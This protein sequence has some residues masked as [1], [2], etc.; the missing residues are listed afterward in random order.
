[1][2][3]RKYAELTEAEIV[4]GWRMARYKFLDPCHGK[5]R[6][7]QKGRRG[8]KGV[9]MGPK[10]DGKEEEKEGGR[11]KE[12]GGRREEEREETNMCR[13]LRWIVEEGQHA[14]MGYLRGGRYKVPRKLE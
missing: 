7:R 14:W 6:A 3:T 2:K 13:Y 9:R 11:R 4:S 8:K 1:L 10:L 5:E 12:E